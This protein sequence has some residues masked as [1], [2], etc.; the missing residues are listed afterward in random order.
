VATLFGFHYSKQMGSNNIFLCLMFFRSKTSKLMCVNRPK[1]RWLCKKKKL[2][3]YCQWL[4]LRRRYAW[5]K[6][7]KMQTFERCP[8]DC[9]LM[10]HLHTIGIARTSESRDFK[11]KCCL[12]T[13]FTI[14]ILFAWIIP[15][16]NIM[17]QFAEFYLS[18]QQ[19][20]FIN[21]VI[22]QTTKLLFCLSIY[23][24]VVS[25]Y[26]ILYKICPQMVFCLSILSFL[27]S[28]EWLVNNSFWLYTEMT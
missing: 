26:I 7:T 21:C 18:F 27:G 14:I 4:C 13:I 8:F 10:E 3:V 16:K 25:N 9:D 17:L 11:T 15:L 22:L 24:K 20:R 1:Y 19:D 2:C 12:C 5:L 6:K 23:F 28:W